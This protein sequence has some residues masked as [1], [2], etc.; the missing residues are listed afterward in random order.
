MGYTLVARIDDVGFEPIKNILEHEMTNKIPYGRNCD[1]EQANSNLPY[2]M[3]LFHWAKAYDEQY[4]HLINHLLFHPFSANATGI[5][6]QHAEEDSSLLYLSVHP[7]ADYEAFCFEFKS[8][9][10]IAL[11]SSLHITLAAS[12]DHFQMEHLKRSV[13]ESVVFPLTITITQIELYHIWQP[14]YLAKTWT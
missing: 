9:T 13:C 1:R 10:G 14:V 8:L 4:L 6:I 2:H 5:S 12:K 7:N 11:P 3:T